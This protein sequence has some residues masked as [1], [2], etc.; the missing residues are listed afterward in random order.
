[1]QLFHHSPYNLGAKVSGE[2]KFTEEQGGT[3]KV[4]GAQEY[5][6]SL[7]SRL[8]DAMSVSA[9]AVAIVAR[10]QLRASRIPALLF[11]YGGPATR[12]SS[13]FFIL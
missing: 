3:W 9:S 4:C 6:L 8:D 10:Q 7:I 2:T 1:M 13:F 11:P 12:E 5:R